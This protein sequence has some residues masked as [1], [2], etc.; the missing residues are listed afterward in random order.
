MGVTVSKITAGEGYKYFT[1]QVTKGDERRPG[2]GMAEY[3]GA[4]G[5]PPGRWLGSGVEALRGIGPL[6]EEIGE[7]EM[8]LRRL[9]HVSW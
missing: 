3:F 9:A 1:E 2:V 4:S 6:S 5:N 8:W 7:E